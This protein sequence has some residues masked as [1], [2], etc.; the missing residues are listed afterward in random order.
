MKCKSCILD[1]S[2]ALAGDALGLEIVELAG[3]GLELQAREIVDVQPEQAGEPA[4][5]RRWQPADEL[6]TSFD[7]LH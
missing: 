5:P 1:G 4:E 7:G 6:A 3:L 2:P